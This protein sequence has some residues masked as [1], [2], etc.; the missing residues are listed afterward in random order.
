MLPPMSVTTYNNIINGI[1]NN[2]MEVANKSM[3]AAAQEMSQQELKDEYSE[4][5]IVNVNISAD[6]S[7]QRR[8]YASL[9][10]NYWYRQR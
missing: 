5:T 10:H 4:D 7:W 3:Q 8:G 2:Y 1:H 9:N 6:G